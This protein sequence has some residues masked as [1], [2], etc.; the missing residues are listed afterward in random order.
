MQVVLEERRDHVPSLLVLP[1]ARVVV[2]ILEEPG[3]ELH[4]G[5]VHL[6]GERYLS[7]LLRR[8]DHILHHD[9]YPDAHSIAENL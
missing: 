8:E 1:R 2:D 5:R 3:P 9:V 6:V 4:E 7:P